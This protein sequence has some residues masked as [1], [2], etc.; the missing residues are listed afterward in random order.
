[1]TTGKKRHLYKDIVEAI[2]TMIGSGQLKVGDKLPPERVLAKRFKVSRNCVRQ[3]VQ[4]LSERKVLESRQG[5]GTYVCAVDESFLEEPFVLAFQLEREFLQDILEFRRL[6]EP[7][8]AALAADRIDRDQLDRLKVIVCD[9]Q[10]KILARE[11]DTPLDAA[12]HTGLAHASG[13][14]VVLRVMDILNDIFDESRSESLQ[15]E[16]RRK[17]S[18]V[19]HLKVIDAL[20]K[21]D[22]GAAHEAM[23]E[24]LAE[25]EGIILEGMERKR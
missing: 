11:D 25:I 21:R 10:R 1:M 9:Q 5:D 23:Q 16:M 19:G 14:R 18:V 13:N 24:H 15:S 3:A 2:W 17:A 12:F 4:A 20:E 6:M 7:Q 8:V 22:P